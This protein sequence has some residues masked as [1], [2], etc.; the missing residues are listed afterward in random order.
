[1]AGPKAL[2]RPPG[3]SRP[4]GA[5]PAVDVPVLAVVAEDVSGGAVDVA[6]VLVTVVGAPVVVGDGSAVAAGAARATRA[7]AQISA[8][9]V[10]GFM[11]SS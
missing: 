3:T 2:D 8:L 9:G 11:H 5:V 1:M 7:T 4:P 10:R 6:V